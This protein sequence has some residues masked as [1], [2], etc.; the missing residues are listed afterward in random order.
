[1][2]FIN[3]YFYTLFLCLFAYKF[4]VIEIARKSFKMNEQSKVKLLKHQLRARQDTI[5]QN[6]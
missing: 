1:M 5:T 3:D 6:L 2:F 4:M